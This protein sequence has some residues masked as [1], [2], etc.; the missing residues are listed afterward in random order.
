MES[1]VSF[2]Q[3][4]EYVV[5]DLVHEGLLAGGTFQDIKVTFAFAGQPKI[6]KMRSAPCNET[7]ALRASCPQSRDALACT[8]QARAGTR[9]PFFVQMYPDAS[10]HWDSGGIPH[11]EP[12][13][14]GRLERAFPRLL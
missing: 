1:D 10:R 8:A 14:N 2:P 9:S 7:R 3:R 6:S 4:D 11:S 13:F 5:R 12:E